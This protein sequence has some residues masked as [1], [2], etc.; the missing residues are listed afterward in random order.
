[1]P[2]RC[3]RYV[4]LGLLHR[5]HGMVELCS[6]SS[7]FSHNMRY[8]HKIFKYLSNCFLRKSDGPT[9]LLFK[10]THKTQRTDYKPRC[11]LHVWIFSFQ[12]FWMMALD[13]CTMTFSL[14]R[15]HAFRLVM[16]SAMN[17]L[18]SCTLKINSIQLAKDSGYS[19]HINTARS[20]VQ[21][22]D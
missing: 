12:H 14:V 2:L 6:N 7:H 5:M 22:K 17:F 16:K 9:H 13:Y 8:F 19:L 1:M 21:K 18:M 15:S 4:P 11:F 10:C 20:R 3:F